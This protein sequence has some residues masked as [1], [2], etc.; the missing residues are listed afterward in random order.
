M[1]AAPERGVDADAWWR[2]GTGAIRFLLAYLASAGLLAAAPPN[3]IIVVGEGQGWAGTSVAMENRPVAEDR[4]DDHVR[5]PAL[6]RLAAEGMR[7]SRHYAASPRCTPS[8]AALL[9]GKSPAQLHMTFVGEGGPGGVRASRRLITPEFRVE[10]PAAETTIAEALRAAG[11]ATAHFGKWHLGRARPGAHG[12]DEDD[13]ANDNGGPENVANPQTRQLGAMT[14]LGLDFL[15]RQA[16]AGRPF[17]L[18]LSHYPS[19]P[20]TVM[21]GRRGRDQ[22]EQE[23]AAAWFDADRALGDVLRRLD[24]LELRRNT[25]VIFTTDHGAPGRNPPFAG[26]KG[27]VGD[28][29]L[30]VPLVIRGPG[31]APGAWS[32]EPVAAVDLF[33][34]LLELAGVTHPLPAGIEGGSLVPLLM[35]GG[36]GTVVRARAGYT[37]HFPHYDKDSAGP[38]SAYYEGDFKLVRTYETG[39][40]ALFNLATDPGERHDLARGTPDQV[41]EMDRRLTEYL[42]DVNA[43]LPVPN[44]RFDPNA[45]TGESPTRGGKSRRPQP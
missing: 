9:T 23:E 4:A 18:Q 33:P 35:H 38:A 40:R 12:F 26:G 32:R 8:R 16:K 24:E 17:L 14:A 34:T 21:A 45:T 10:L 37:V 39:A 41:A 2:G 13:G 6:E 28:G 25:Y 42:R 3:F 36:T 5:T 30:R 15:G 43:G 27:T 20:S 22:R 11:Y 1:Q 44:P 7:F 31:I 29:G 19:R